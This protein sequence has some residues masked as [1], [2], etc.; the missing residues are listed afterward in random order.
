MMARERILESLLELSERRTGSRPRLVAQALETAVELADCDGA[1]LLTR[2]GR[3]F[4]RWS[5]T[6]GHPR[7]AAVPAPANGSDF[8]RS[9][10][11]AGHAWMVADLAEDA[12]LEGDG[13]PG[14]EPGPALFVPLRTRDAAPCYLAVY[15]RRSGATFTQEEI[16]LVTLLAAWTAVAL[17]NQ[18]L[19]ANLEKLAVT[20]D[21]TQVHNYRFLKSALRR[22]L[23]RAARFQQ[24]LSLIMVDVD[25]LKGYNDRNGHMRGSMLLRDIAQLL[26]KHVRSFDLVAKYGGDEFTV[27]L[28]QT[29]PDGARVVAERLRRAIE[30]HDFPLAPPGTITVSMGVAAFPEDAADPIGLIQASDRALYAAKKAGRNRVEVLRELAA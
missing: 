25:N 27:I 1:T 15:R 19:S 11:R 5:L 23:K 4:E 12:R 10:A 24:N 22:E 3:A 13:C 20:D 18:R 8:A 26:A 30:E 14:V 9:L 29:D 21:L 28:P 2:R 7:T 16:R 17:E 6:R